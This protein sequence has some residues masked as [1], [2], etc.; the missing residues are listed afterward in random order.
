MNIHRLLLTCAALLLTA[1]APA[2]ALNKCVGPNGGVVF[3]DAPCAGQGG[4]II[5]RPAS[6][7]GGGNGQATPPKPT[8]PAAPGGTGSPTTSPSLPPGIVVDP[9]PGSLGTPAQPPAS[10]AVAQPRQSPHR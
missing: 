1:S 4:A 2:W 7:D 9:L 5:V 10:T 3:Q 6:G 8:P